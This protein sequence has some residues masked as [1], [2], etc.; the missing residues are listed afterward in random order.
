MSPNATRLGRGQIYMYYIYILISN[1][2][3]KYYVGYT[4][5]LKLRL[6]QHKAGKVLSTKSRLPVKLVYYEAF[7]N[8]TDALR[9]ELFLKTGK[10]RER[11]DYLLKETKKRDK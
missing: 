2:D 5:N 6:E 9:E 11:L 4:H 8:K 3:H 7:S 1:K 10:G